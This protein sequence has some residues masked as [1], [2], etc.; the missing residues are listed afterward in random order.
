MEGNAE[1]VWWGTDS[2]LLG[3]LAGEV[4]IPTLDDIIATTYANSSNQIYGWTYVSARFFHENYP[5]EMLDLADSLRNDDGVGYQAKLDALEE[6]YS[7]EFALWA[8]Q[9]ITMSGAF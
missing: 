9:L 5:E 6:G 4:G 1:Y 2:N 7:F 3:T 8:Q